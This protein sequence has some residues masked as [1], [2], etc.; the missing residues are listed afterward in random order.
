MAID[1]EDPLVQQCN[2]TNPYRIAAGYVRDR[3]RWDMRPESWRSRRRLQTLRNT[4]VGKKAII[5]CN[6]PSLLKVD[7]DLASR[8]FTFG[9]NKINLLFDKT[10]F[11]PSCVVSVNP[12]VIEQNTDFFNSTTIPLFLDSNAYGVVRSR[13]NVTFLHSSPIRR[14]SKDCSV[15]IYQGHTVT[16][17]AM[18]LAFHMG[19][20]EVALVGCDHNFAVKGPANKTVVSGDKDESHFD[21]YYFAGGVKWQLPDL[22]QSEVSYFMAKQ[23]FEAYGRQ[24]V[25]CTEGGKLDLLERK[26]L[27]DFIGS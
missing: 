14:F 5:L 17:V 3:L 23:I 15:S 1:N 9:L 25:N 10:G 7:F 2:V 19:F 13:D 4:H 6:G 22:F 16:F 18:Q 27:T 21:P 11:R 24:L 26:L 12:F 8:A 20:S